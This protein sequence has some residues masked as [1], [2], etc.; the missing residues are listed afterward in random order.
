MEFNT[1]FAAPEKHQVACVAAGVFES[2]KLSGA[3]DALDKAAH[4]QIRELLRS[5]DMDGKV[6]TTRLLYRMRGVTAE[7]V[8][9][10]GLGREKEFGEKQYRDCA[11]AAFTAI[12]ETGARDACLYFAELQVPG[13]D[14]AWKTSQLVL[15]AADVAYRFDRMKSK[16]AEERSLVHVAIS[17]VSKR[18]AAAL[19]HGLREG[20]AIAAGTA[21]ELDGSLSQI[22][23][24]AHV[25]G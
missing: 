17:A 15:A 8:L 11:R 10:V 12:Q 19:E 24:R 13:R 6:G 20:R 2:R 7:R 23:G 21:L 16:K 22:R 18:D 5:G 4:G 14:A 1:K 25:S 3:A 9:L